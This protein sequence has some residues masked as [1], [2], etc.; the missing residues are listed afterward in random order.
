MTKAPAKARVDILDALRG[1]A[2][3]GVLLVNLRYYSLYDVLTVDAQARLATAGVDTFIA[4]LFA[5]LIDTK[6]ITLFTFL[7][8]IGFALQFDESR[9]D[10]GATVRY[11]R[12]LGVLLAIGFVHGMVIWSGDILRYYAVAGIALVM[13]ARLPTRWLLAIG[14][15]I[16]L[17]G[18]SLLRPL[19]API[20]AAHRNPG[21]QAAA[22]A[23]FQQSDLAV[24]V[25]GNWDYATY[26]SLA[27]WSLF[28][29]VLGRVL[30]GVAIGRSG[31]LVDVAAH[32]A[33]WRALLVGGMAVGLPLTL[34][35]IARDAGMWS[36][37]IAWRSEP[38]RTISG[39]IRATGSIALASAWMAAFAL[40]FQNLQ[41]RK[42]LAGFAAVGRM[43][44]TNYLAQTLC[45]LLLFYGAGLGLGPR[46]GL[47]G[48]L[49]ATIAIFTTQWV[50]SA[51]WLARFRYGP[52][53]WIWR[54]LT[55]VRA[56]PLR[57][58]AS[59]NA[60]PL[61]ASPSDG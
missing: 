34:F 7:F 15:F 36:D 37:A 32:R 38:W 54:C 18:A 59:A 10:P 22:L 51:W 53:E 26:E 49:I 50:I 8:G 56:L 4:P 30:I 6:S 25:A 61:A 45:G 55:Y 5:V 42:R 48:V 17:F 33:F 13:C 24:T 3:I 1:F 31:V 27:N 35:V 52:V 40:L 29:F 16:A 46:F 47:P 12:R 9:R 21:A 44:L 43:A 23:A 58:M 57:R 11:L 2:L 14:T 39:A 41:W 60:S 20:L 19:L 28:P